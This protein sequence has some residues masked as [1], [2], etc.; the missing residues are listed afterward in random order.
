T[1]GVRDIFVRDRATDAEPRLS[2]SDAQVTEGSGFR[3]GTLVFTVSLSAVSSQ[4][5]SFRF[6]T[7]DVSA[8]NGADYHGTFGTRTIPAGGTSTTITVALF[9]D[10]TFEQND[11][12][13]LNIDT[14]LNATIADGQGV[15][16]ILNDD[17][18]IG[19]TLSPGTFD[20]TP[21]NA[22]VAV[23]EHLTY[24]L[25]WTVPSGSWHE[26]QSVDLR[27]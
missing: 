5:V 24:R 9:G 21:A 16:T 14:P 6:W 2:V 23:G 27:I 25:T 15:G 13:H 12:M 4:D 8:R 7:E 3:P 17:P 20:L 11:T 18:R 19:G 22:A 26:L 1:N 10:S